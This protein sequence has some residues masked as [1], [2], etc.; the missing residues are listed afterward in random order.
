MHKDAGL[1][2]LQATDSKVWGTHEGRGFRDPGP[3]RNP[4]FLSKESSA[5][6]AAEIHPSFKACSPE[7]QGLHEGWSLPSL[8][9]TGNS[10]PQSSALLCP[11]L[12]ELTL[13]EIPQEPVQR[14]HHP[15]QGPLP[16][17]PASVTTA[18]CHRGHIFCFQ[19]GNKQGSKIDTTMCYETSDK[20]GA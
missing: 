12:G 9:M 16:G 15:N 20:A 5:A 1:G 19:K 7:T 14:S 17:L 13:Q 4:K 3:H 11:R 8:Q 18:M 2:I 10:T 6:A